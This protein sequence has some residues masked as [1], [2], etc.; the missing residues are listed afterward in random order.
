M[1]S[2]GECEGEM[3]AFGAPRAGKR[4]NVILNRQGAKNAKFFTFKK[5][6]LATL[7]SWRQIRFTSF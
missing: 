6:F 4:L 2:D 1:H 7:A 5:A 3:P